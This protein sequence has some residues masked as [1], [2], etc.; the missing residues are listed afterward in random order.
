MSQWRYISNEVES[1]PVSTEQLRQMIGQGDGQP[2]GGDYPTSRWLPNETIVEDRVVKP[3]NPTPAVALALGL[4]RLADGTRLPIVSKMRI[5]I[6]CIEPDI[7]TNPPSL[8]S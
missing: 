1:G 7:A 8:H 6:D 3:D 4:Y 5:A 2:F